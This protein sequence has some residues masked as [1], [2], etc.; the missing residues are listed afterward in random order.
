MSKLQL[1]VLE[2]KLFCIKYHYKENNY[3]ALKA[4]IK[5]SK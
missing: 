1:Q 3:Q 2:Y 5:L 4:F